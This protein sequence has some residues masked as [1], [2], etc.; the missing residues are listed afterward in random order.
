MVQKKYYYS[1][2]KFTDPNKEKKQVGLR[3]EK[4]SKLTI[5]GVLQYFG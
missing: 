1:G 2:H 4:F 3:T 5:T